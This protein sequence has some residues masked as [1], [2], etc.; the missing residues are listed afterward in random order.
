[1]TKLV[2]AFRSFVKAH[3]NSRVVMRCFG[4]E[5]TNTFKS[6]ILVSLIIYPLGAGDSAENIPFG[7]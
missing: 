2:V 4:R 7:N 3:K 1:M 5:F 6:R